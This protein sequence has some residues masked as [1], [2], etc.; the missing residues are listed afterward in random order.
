LTP[1]LSS[2]SLS[3]SSSWSRFHYFCWFSLL[4]VIVVVLAAVVPAAAARLVVEFAADVAKI[5]MP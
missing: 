2:W 4:L 5:V 1:F 3:T